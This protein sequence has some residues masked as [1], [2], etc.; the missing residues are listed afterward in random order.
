MVTIS[1]EQ[2]DAA[3]ADNNWSLG[4]KILYDMCQQYPWHKANPEIVAK[5]W[6]IGRSYAAA[7]ERRKKDT[8]GR[9]LVG[10]EFY[11]KKVAPEIL[12]SNIDIWLRSLG[13]LDTVSVNSLSTI[14]SVHLQV[15]EL[16]LT[17]SGL[18]KRSLAS[19]YLHFHY[20]KL[21][22]IYDIRA[23]TAVSHLSSITGRVG[24]SKYK[25]DNE[26][27]KFCEKCIKIRDHVEKLYG[28][29]LTP[30]SLD[31]LL[32]VIEANA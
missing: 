22:F 5:V 10:D 30:R 13:G 7:I 24:R 8:K 6:L 20:P 2:V 23:V 29:S 15:T 27:R 28:V 12:K 17:I 11:F 14:L 32:L 3:V 31:N 4:N 9:K 25:S 21:F 1:K 26:Y 18:E 16:F 19:K